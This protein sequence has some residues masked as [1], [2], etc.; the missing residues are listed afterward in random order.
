MISTTAIIA[1]DLVHY[2]LIGQELS[3]SRKNDFIK[4]M[5]EIAQYYINYIDGVDFV[6]EGSHADYVYSK[7]LY[8]NAKSIIDKE[9]RFLFAKSPDISIEVGSM[10]EDKEKA[11]SS[12]YQNLIDTVLKENKI[13]QKLIKSAKDCFIGK[14]VAILMNFNEEVGIDITFVNSLQFIY[15][16]ENSDSDVLSMVCAFIPIVESTNRSESRIFKKKYWMEGGYCW[17]SEAVYDGNG[18]KV[19]EEEAPTIDSMRTDFEYIPAVIVLND[20][21]I[22]D[23][24]G[25]SEMALLQDYEEYFNKLSNADKDAE[26]KSMNPIKVTIDASPES[27]GNLSSSA[28]SYWDLK[29]DPTVTDTRSASVQNLEASMAYST[30]LKTTLDRIKNN[31]YEQVDVPNTSPEALQGI[32]T[33]G[34]T[35][36]AIYWGLVVR[37]DEKMLSWIPALEFIVRTIV[38]GSRLFPNIAKRYIKDALPEEDFNVEIVNNYPLPEDEL[39]EKAVDMEEVTSEVMSKKSYMKKW[40]G[41]TDKEADAELQQIALEKEILESYGLP[42]NEEDSAFEDSSESVEGAKTIE[43]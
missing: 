21:L 33:S 43:D 24:R 28:G 34:K 4:E 3:G 20:G 30:A 18:E 31:M 40:R 23:E 16:T 39:E 19:D 42:T 14:R 13:N 7:L 37:C 1:R 10:S 2:E 25:E 11:D 12:I 27:T 36:K 41:L 35:L 38:H 9:A 15:E 22:G 29:T 5:G 6:P 17:V 8:R 32:V 26:R